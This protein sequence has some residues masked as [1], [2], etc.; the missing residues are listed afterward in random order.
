L[1]L[2]VVLFEMH[3]AAQHAVGRV[4]VAVDD[5]GPAVKVIR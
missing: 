3:V 4:A 2:G 5:D 1:R